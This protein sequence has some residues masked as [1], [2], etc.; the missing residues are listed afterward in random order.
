MHSRLRSRGFTLIELLVGAAVGAVVLLGISM[1]FI[2]QAQQYQSHASRRAIQANARQALAFMERKVRSAG[3]GVNPDR[4]IIAYDSYDV[5][6]DTA[7]AGYPDAVAVHSRDPL[8]RRTVS[9]VDT[10]QIVLTAGNGLTVPMRRG[11][12]LLLVCPLA[13]KYAFVTVDGYLPAG[14]LNI[15][16]S[17]V[18]PAAAPNSP[19]GAPGR[20]FREHATLGDPCF[21]SAT[22]VKVDRAA[23]Y[24]AMFDAD[25]DPATDGRTPYLMMHQGLDMPT[26][27]LVDGDGVIDA[28]DAVPVAE[29]IEQLQV[30]YIL[31]VNATRQQPLIVGVN[32][33]P[34]L[35]PE[36]YGEVWESIDP[37]KNS[38]NLA[39]GIPWY[40]DTGRV[41]PATHAFYAE[42]HPAN[43]RQVRLSV[44]AR[45]TV[46]DQQIT[47]DDLLTAAEGIAL[48][49][50][51]I[52]WRQFE[53]L[54]TP[55]SPDFSPK[56]GG[57]YRVILRES[58]TPK[59]LSM[60]AQF[61]PLTFV[62]TSTS[63]GG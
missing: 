15:P 54:G 4:A 27:A 23:F 41:P 40:F 33:A 32:E 37:D 63:G 55:G 36:H 7:V 60:N 48:P 2:S 59:N 12:I 8:F 3:Y 42:D 24:V 14:T 46:S 5:V 30:A 28:N 11:Q 52:P 19:I 10:T 34:M 57:Y 47:G 22:V 53:N 31:N 38:H 21:D 1:T 20:L 35:G 39:W 29:G 61:P 6:T 16:L 50:G 56:G 51:T 18:V 43:I 25:G 45:S 26:D 58:I 13:V 17:Q 9:Q 44:V 62:D 49:D